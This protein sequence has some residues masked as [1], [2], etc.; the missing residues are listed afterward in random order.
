MGNTKRVNG[1]RSGHHVRVHFNFLLMVFTDILSL[2]YSVVISQRPPVT[3]GQSSDRLK[4]LQD[5]IAT[6][7]QGSPDALVLRQLAFLCKENPVDD[8]Q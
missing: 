3:N 7:E 1:G 8:S 6:L 2:T 5:H 4:Q